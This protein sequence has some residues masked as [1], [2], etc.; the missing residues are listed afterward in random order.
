VVAGIFGGLTVK[1]SIL[2]VQA[3][4]ALLALVFVIV[5]RK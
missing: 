4:P 1:T 5:A 2:Y 3:A